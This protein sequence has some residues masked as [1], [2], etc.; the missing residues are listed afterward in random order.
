MKAI[1]LWIGIAVPVAASESVETGGL[2]VLENQALRLVIRPTA[3]PF[4]ER[5]IHKASGRAVVAA[6]APSSLTMLMSTVR[7][8]ARHSAPCGRIGACPTSSLPALNRWRS[9]SLNCEATAP[10]DRNSHSPLLSGKSSIL[11]I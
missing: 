11:G 8:K 1:V 6:P 3:A 7:R 10:Q 4:I 5:L 2:F 9:C